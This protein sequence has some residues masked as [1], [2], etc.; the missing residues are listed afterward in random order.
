MS[1]D[2]ATIVSAVLPSAVY[3]LRLTLLL[4][5]STLLATVA[6]DGVAEEL[7]GADP[8]AL[9]QMACDHPRALAFIEQMLVPTPVRFELA[10]PKSQGDEAAERYG[11]RRLFLPDRTLNYIA[12]LFRRMPP[13]QAFHAAHGLGSA[14]DTKRAPDL[15]FA[16]WDGQFPERVRQADPGM[17]RLE[18]MLSVYFAVYPL[19]SSVAHPQTMQSYKLESTMDAFKKF[20]ETRGAELC[21]TSQFLQ[22]YALPYVPDPRQHPSFQDIFSAHWVGEIGGRLQQFLD[23]ALASGDGRPRLLTLLDGQASRRVI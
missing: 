16:L 14:S 8:Y 15:F 6:F 19:L 17:Q 4:S 3:M 13:F 12:P 5:D 18:F 22:Y 7:I 20:L 10:P 21:K 23:K 1:S 2:F 9:D 11:P